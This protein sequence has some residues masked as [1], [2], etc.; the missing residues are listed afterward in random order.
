MQK[1]A[2][3]FVV[4]VAAALVAGTVPVRAQDQPAPPG[5]SKEPAPATQASVAQGQLLRVD[6]NA[7]AIEIRSSEGTQ[8]QFR[9]TDDTKVTGADKGVSGL[10]TMAGSSVT[11]HF[12]K[13]GQ[14]NI[15]T[16]IE[17]QAAKK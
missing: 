5:Q 10:A 17:V 4:F 2:R 12:S 13:Q 6:P 1:V 9:Y 16:E 11:V 15:A 3:V 7:K 8:M 14:D